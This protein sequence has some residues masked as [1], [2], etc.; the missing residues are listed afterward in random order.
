M[1]IFLV[2]VIHREKPIIDSAI[3][4]N[5]KRESKMSKMVTLVPPCNPFNQI[6]KLEEVIANKVD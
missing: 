4:Q 1:H 6:N 3:A 5:H 2:S